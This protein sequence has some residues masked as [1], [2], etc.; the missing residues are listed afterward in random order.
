MTHYHLP[1]SVSEPCL[2]VVF[3]SSRMQW[4]PDFGGNPVLVIINVPQP[5]LPPLFGKAVVQLRMP[6]GSYPVEP[7]LNVFY[8]HWRTE[9]LWSML[10]RYQASNGW[11][12]IRSSLRTRLMLRG[13]GKQ[14]QQAS[15]HWPPGEARL[16]YRRKCTDL[17]IQWHWNCLDRKTYFTVVCGQTFAHRWGLRWLHFSRTEPLFSCAIVLLPY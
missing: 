5:R 11:A 6:Y 3:W 12:K 1:R 2:Y 16:T 17:C 15:A 4:K 14:G 13:S 9:D 8:K 7:L 10:K